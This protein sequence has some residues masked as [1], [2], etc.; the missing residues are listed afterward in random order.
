MNA[1]SPSAPSDSFEVRTRDDASGALVVELAGRFTL[2]EA[3]RFWHD[4]QTALKARRSHCIHF[5]LSAVD[6]MG[7][8]I[9]AL[10]VG[11][12]DE[13]QRNG[14]ETQF[15]GIGESLREM[16]DLYH[17]RETLRGPEAVL[18]VS[19][20]DHIGRQTVHVLR[21]A[22]GM[23]EFLGR[24]AQAFGRGV[25]RP[26]T[27]A[28][29]AIPRLLERAGADAIPIVVAIHFLIGLTMAFQSA[30]RLRNYGAEIFTA[31]VV[32]LAQTR[33]LGPLITA[34]ILAG[35]SGAAYAA[36]IGSMKINEEVDAL[37]MLG[38]CEFRYLVFPRIMTLLIAMP[39][40]AM[41]ANVVGI[42]GGLVVGVTTLDLT[43]TAYLIETQL[44]IRISDVMTGLFKAVVFG[45]TIAL[46][47]CQRG[48][49]TRG[50][51]EGVGYFTTSSVV[52]ILFSLIA[53]DAIFTILFHLF[54]V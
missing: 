20:L 18:Q 11:M 23:L 4:L 44:A 32:G 36:E 35:R 51:A 53:L 21:G 10:L 28:W 34:I 52:N 2:Q 14:C 39:C 27:L 17:R 40:L 19:L 50:G 5:D 25:R 43:P 49:A 31:D 13:A 9:L 42:F 48:L 45:G 24:L 7:S 8:G 3:E 54:Q 1:G 38:I 26:W 6:H 37:K 47:S 30:L 16:L 33:E 15:L 29:H 46:I 12:R 41:I 22:R